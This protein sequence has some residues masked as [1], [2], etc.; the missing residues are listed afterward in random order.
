MANQALMANA[1]RALAMDAV[2]QANSGHP[3]APMGMADMAVALWGEHLR[4]NPANPHWFDRDR[5]VLSNGHA[6]MLLYAVLHLTGYDLPIDELKNFRQL[7]SKTAGHPEVDVTPGVETTTGPLGQGITNAVGFALAEKLLAAEFNRKSHDIVDHHTYAFLGD[8]CMMEGISHEACALA[9][10]WHLNKL[11]ALYDDNGI[12]ID[13]QVKPWFIDNTEE[14]FKA[15]GWNVIGPID[16]N[17]AKE[18]S[19]AIAKA[20]KEESRPTLIVCKTTIGKGSP[21]RAGTAKAHGEALGAEEIKLTREA[22]GW[23]APAFEIPTEVY[24]DWNHKDEGHR[25][26]TDWNERFAAYAVAYPELAGEFTRRMKG[27]LP[28]E[29]HQVAFDTVVAAHTKAET[30]ASRKA[31]QLA[32]E[33][34]T[35]AL[36]EMLGGSADL[37]GSNLTNTKSTAALRFDP[38][39][40]AVVMN[41]P[42]VEAKPGAEDEAKSEAPAEAPHGTIGRH[43]N[44]GV[45]EFGMAAIMNGV[46]LHGGYIPYGGT[47]LTFSDYSRNAIRMA[48]LMKHRV[49]HVF[50][51][52]SIGLGEDG[53]THQSIEHAAS[54]RLIPNLDVWRPGDTAETAVAWAVA[55][56]NQSRPT[57]LLLSRQN[58]AYAAKSELGDISRGAYVLSEPENVGLKNKKT[59][60]VLIATGSEVQLALAAQK[61]LAEKKIAVRVVSMPSTTTFDRQDLA[62]KKAVLP[63]K[64]PRV[65]VEMG[66]TDGWWK[67]GCAAVVGIDTYGESAPAPV[68]FKHFGFTAENVAATVEAALRD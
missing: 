32:L 36:P 28:K 57:A 31:S 2:Q 35:A 7:H 67:Y 23:T 48:A 27:E 11:I 3:G 26:E 52:D 65:A 61:L 5:F 50:T 55:L 30:V 39:T 21:N 53:P 63:K 14:R 24:A 20:K 44:Y 66:C 15:Y 68:L 58:I 10:A 60:A 37:T 19:K 45:R 6:S 1:I 18:V 49:I 46:A 64:L 4:Y 12:S 29:F 16:G 59:A 25:L 17:D 13:G 33:S 40:G 41:V 34:F 56:Q 54:L 62:Y 47:F 43:I 51:H 9:G 38:K 42:A 22:L 8:G